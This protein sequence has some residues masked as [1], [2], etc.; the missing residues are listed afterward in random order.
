MKSD[1]EQDTSNIDNAIIDLC[2]GID[3]MIAKLLDR[4]DQGVCDIGTYEGFD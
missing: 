2:D 3:R 1:S 4:G